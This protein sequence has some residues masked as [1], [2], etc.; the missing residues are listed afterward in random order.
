RRGI[1]SLSQLVEAVAGARVKG[2]WWAHPKGKEIF[3]V[4]TDLE[5]SPDVLVTKMGKVIFVHRTLWP[6]LLRL[7]T[8]PAW[9]RRAEKGAGAPA[10]RSLR[11]VEP[12]GTLRMA[13]EKDAR[14]ELERRGLVLS[15]SEHTES[16]R[17]A[18]VLT[19]WRSWAPPDVLAEARALEPAAAEERLRTAG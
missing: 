2:S 5:G 6:A 19:S 11:D 17:H 12:A 1:L 4:A 16:G 13:G 15:T 10:G 7:V 3:R 14:A 8:D 9:R 18:A